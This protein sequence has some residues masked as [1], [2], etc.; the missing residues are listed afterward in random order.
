MLQHL[1]SLAVEEQFY[2]LWPLLAIGLL[3]SV[4]R[5]GGRWATPAMRTGWLAAVALLLAAASTVEM[6]LLAISANVPYDSDGSR[7]Y[8]G[9]D[10]HS[11]GLLLGAALGALAAGRSR[12]KPDAPAR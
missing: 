8:Y 3:S 2:L 10:T 4:G 1:W 9:T 6:A 11:M 12:P 5:R 7:L